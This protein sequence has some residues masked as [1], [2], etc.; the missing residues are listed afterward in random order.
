MSGFNWKKVGQAQVFGRGRYLKDGRYTLRF[1]KM[2]TIETRK[3]GHALVAEFNVESSNN[4]EI[5][6]GTKRN[7]YQS[8]GDKDIAF[9]AVK[10]FMLSLLNVDQED[11]DE[12]EEFDSKLDVRLE[13][14]SD[15]KWQN[16]D[17]KK[18]PLHGRL[19]NCE[20]YIKETKKGGEFTVHDWSPCDDEE[21]EDRPKKKKAEP[22]KSK[23][24]KS[25]DYDDDDDD[26]EDED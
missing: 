20:C 13:K 7:W 16:L 22:V 21:D 11:E 17:A 15:S 25:R 24:K 4:D 3:S 18:H 1:L 6:E 19:I 14:Y 8:L 23:A 26:D 9:P 2:Y 12:M 10:E 5:P